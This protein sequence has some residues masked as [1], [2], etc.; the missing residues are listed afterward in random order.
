MT[1]TS[2]VAAPARP[3]PPSR[4]GR[5]QAL[6]AL[7]RFESVRMLRHP[8]TIAAALLFLAPWLWDW[9]AGSANRYPVLPDELITINLLALPILGGSALIVANLVTL[10]AHRHK[11]DPS[12]D[13]LVL[14]PA[15]RVGGFLL[16]LL[17]LAALTLLLV[18]VRVGVSAA[19]PGAARSVDVAA[20]LTPSALTLLLGATGV[21]S[22][23]LIR[24]V[25][26]A[27][28]VVL[29]VLVLEFLAIT[30]MLIETGW[31]F[32]LP[33]YISDFTVPV[34]AGVSDR[35]AARHL[36]YLV[37]I[38]VLLAAAVLARANARRQVVAGG[39]VVGLILAVGGGLTQSRPDPGLAAA[40]AT[41]EDRP[42]SIQSCEIRGDVTYCFFEGFDGFVPG[43]D[44]VVTSVRAVVPA[45]AASSG[46]PLAVRQRTSLDA[47]TAGG[48][49][50]STAEDRRRVAAWKV[51]DVA[52]GTP[53]AVQVGTAWGDD[54]AA[55]AL[56]AGVAYRLMAAKAYD[57]GSLLCGARAALL[58]WLVGRASP[59]TLAGL[60]SLDESS[61]GGLSLSD[62]S[63]MY[64]IA[65]SDRAAAPALELLERA[66]EV[67]PLVERHW[68]ELTAPD[69]P[70]ERFGAIFGVPIQPLAPDDDTLPCV[71]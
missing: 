15:W 24:S 43:W 49:T 41:V 17:S 2:T 46:P 11:V 66:A 56:A 14:P 50:G 64:G 45:S 36:V 67:A 21:L 47:I 48:W 23:V 27:P 7:A 35:P 3:M 63:F 20:M 25:L 5:R 65:A 8:L 33:V 57:G 59:T 6:L 51:E 19:L 62:M 70:L 1:A 32:L 55:A 9:L 42:A 26:I 60:R 16:A 54:R 61:T 53:E 58:V 68:A 40:R 18:A 71:P 37:G 29:L 12:Y 10:R 52:A 22:G 31:R 69:T 30:P 4:N 38:T 44:A 34:P 13:V 39:L 28:L